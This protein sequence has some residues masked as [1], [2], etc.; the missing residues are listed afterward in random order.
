MITMVYIRKRLDG[1]N[2]L[3]DRL[4]TALDATWAFLQ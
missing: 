3:L 2:E 4:R 1:S